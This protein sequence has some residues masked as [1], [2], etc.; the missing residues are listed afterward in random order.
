MA[1]LTSQRLQH[2]RQGG[3]VAA[4][5]PRLVAAPRRLPRAAR[6]HQLQCNAVAEVEAP[7]SQQS[8]AKAA[9]GLPAYD[10][11]ASGGSGK[12]RIVVLGTGWAS[13]SFVRAF[14]E[15]MRDK[16][17]LIMVSPRNYF[18]YTPL[19]PAM[20]AGT[21]EERSIVESVRAV[22]GGKG[23]FFEAQCTDILPQEKAIV[24]CFPED[25]GFPEACF[26]ISYD[27]LVLG[28][29]THF[30]SAVT[31]EW[32]RVKGSNGT[33]FALGDAATIEQNKAVEKASELF[34]KYAA[35]HSDG[36]LTLEELQ[37]L[38]RE[39][40]QEFPHLR[41]HATFLD[42][43]VGS[44]RFG[45]LVFN[46]FL[47][48]NQTMSTMYKGVGLV[49]PQSTL[50]REQF[51]ELLTRIDSSL[52]ALPATAQVARQ[53]GEYLAEAFKLADGDLEE[54]PRAAPGFK[55]FHKGSMAYVGG[56]RGWQLQAS[57]AK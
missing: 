3:L 50:S 40:S 33:M 43:K 34:D 29:G 36:R 53:Q 35:T 12:P 49:D 23:K 28:V 11:S 14:D 19:L 54:L 21:V 13:M 18:V 7:S 45:G 31:D 10:K 47:Q 30:R 38:M 52:R 42:G 48:A 16:Y 1:A 46:A 41:E 26:K 6:K 4:R 25:A 37:Q 32:L 56:G 2:C 24:A 15:A 44:Q 5:P 20:C 9:A 51:S 22:L 17:E 27:Y 8:G 55:Y 57:T 39:A